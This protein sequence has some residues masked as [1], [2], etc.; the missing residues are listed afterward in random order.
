MNGAEKQYQAPDSLDLFAL[1][2]RARRTIGE[3]IRP[4]INEL[5]ED[6]RKVAE[7]NSKQDRINIRL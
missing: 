6:R 5:D 7:V 4:I 3:L 1:E 2:T